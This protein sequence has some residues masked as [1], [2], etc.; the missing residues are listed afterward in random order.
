MQPT[1]ATPCRST[2]S[3]PTRTT[4]CIK[5]CFIKRQLLLCSHR[6]PSFPVPNCGSSGGNGRC[7]VR[8][9]VL[10]ITGISQANMKPIG[11]LIS[12]E[13]NN[14]LHFIWRKTVGF[15]A[16]LLVIMA[17]SFFSSFLNFKNILDM[18]IL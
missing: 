12:S 1:V 9:L 13:G 16:E 11:L 15:A 17:S 18:P 2:S 8:R 4:V 3:N 5:M 14:R 7:S 6:S 10:F